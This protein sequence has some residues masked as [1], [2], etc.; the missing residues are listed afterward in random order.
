MAKGKPEFL[1]LPLFYF[2]QS[3]SK[4]IGLLIYQES[5]IFMLFLIFWYLLNS[6]V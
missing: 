6:F 4:C 1:G 3:D 2:L 5:G